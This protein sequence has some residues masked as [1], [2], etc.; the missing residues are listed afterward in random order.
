MRIIKYLTLVL[1]ISVSLVSVKAQSNPSSPIFIEINRDGDGVYVIELLDAPPMFG[2]M[3]PQSARVTVYGLDELNV[4]FYETRFDAMSGGYARRDDVRFINFITVAQDQYNQNFIQNAGINNSYL[5][6][7]PI[8]LEPNEIVIIRRSDFDDYTLRRIFGVV[9]FRF[10]RDMANFQ[11]IQMSE[12]DFVMRFPTPT[13]AVP[14][15]LITNETN[16]ILDESR[17]NPP[18]AS[19]PYLDRSQL[20]NALNLRD[21]DLF[22]I[23][24]TIPIQIYPN[25]G[26][27]PSNDY[28]P[29]KIIRLNMGD[30]IIPSRQLQVGQIIV[31]LNPNTRG[32]S[33]TTL[34]SPTTDNDLTRATIH[35]FD[36]AAGRIIVR[37][38]GSEVDWIVNQPWLIGVEVSG[39]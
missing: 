9:A 26:V 8:G 39:P 5:A 10:D 20:I 12:G 28:S 33:A 30:N 37:V 15:F 19:Y 2:L 27:V 34:G 23:M 6:T 18:G 16:L 7:R 22:E 17:N 35:R 24:R 13:S 36:N 3:L 25:G 38:A 31:P 29:G 4:E 11:L 1:F 32:I 21:I 14:Y